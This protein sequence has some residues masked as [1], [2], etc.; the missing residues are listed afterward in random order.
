KEVVEGARRYGTTV[1]AIMADLASPE[2]RAGLV[3][4]AAEAL[5]GPIDLLINNAAAAMYQPLVDYPSK[6]SHLTFEVNV[7]APLDLAQQAI[8]AMVER[9][10]GWIVNVSSATAN[11]RPG[12]PF[13]LPPPGSH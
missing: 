10:E 11:L 2:S 5:G 6:R 9:G 4:R 7:H 3:G 12:P 8:P 1:E 13:H